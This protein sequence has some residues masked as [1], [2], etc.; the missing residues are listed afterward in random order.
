M[1]KK[2]LNNKT[3]SGEIQLLSVREFCNNCKWIVDQ[4]QKEFPNIKI[5]RIHL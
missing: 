1:R 4:F 5:I 3:V 2:F